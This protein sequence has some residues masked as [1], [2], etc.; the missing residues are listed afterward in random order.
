MKKLITLFFILVLLSWSFFAGIYFWRSY[1]SNAS[2]NI[3]DININSTDISQDKK[4]VTNRRIIIDLHNIDDP[5]VIWLPSEY[6][7]FFKR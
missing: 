7:V 2:L 3:K 5:R 1:N 4:T 6:K